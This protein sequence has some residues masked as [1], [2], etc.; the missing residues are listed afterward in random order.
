VKPTLHLAGLQ[1]SNWKEHA[2]RFAFGGA[3]TVIAGVVAH[4]FGPFIGGLFLA[5]PAILPASLTL[6]KKHDGRHAEV[7][8][9]RGAT[10]A[11]FGL[12]AF[13]IALPTIENLPCWLALLVAVVAWML[14]AGAAWTI[15][16]GRRS[17][18]SSS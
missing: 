3:I 18:P 15:V 1:E 17:M 12:A 8:D 5:F 14:T 13:A 11:A 4:A 2:I 9:A 7:E 6:V 16:D 10:L